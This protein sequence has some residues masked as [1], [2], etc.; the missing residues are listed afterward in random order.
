MPCPGCRTSSLCPCHRGWSV[1]GY[2]CRE[3]M[4]DMS[5][6]GCRRSHL[7]RP[8]E[9]CCDC[10]S[11]GSQVQSSHRRI[12][13]RGVRCSD[14]HRIDRCD[15]VRMGRHTCRRTCHRSALYSDRRSRRRR[16][17]GCRAQGDATRRATWC[18]SGC[19]GRSQ[20]GVE[21]NGERVSVKRGG[22]RMIIAY[23]GVDWRVC[24]QPPRVRCRQHFART[25]ALPRLSSA[26]LVSLS[27]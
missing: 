7:S 15:D 26:Q 6:A 25:S 22:R 5:A 3:R 17:S 4:A 13:H 21:S 10:A 8:K 11:Y 20:D 27:A 19:G 23:S 14:H 18:C 16:T 9:R 24:A 12:C 1:C 2:E